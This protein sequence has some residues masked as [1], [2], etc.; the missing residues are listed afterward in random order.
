VS[1]N[2]T[3]YDT[4]AV[5]HDLLA[6]PA[7]FAAPARELAARMDFDG[8]R[9]ALDVGTGSGIVAMAAAPVCPVVVGS[10]PSIEMLRRA[11][12]NGI[13][14][15]VTAGVPGLPFANGAFDRV[16]AGFVLSHVAAREAALADMARV[17]RPGGRLGLTAWNNL[18]NPYRDFWDRLAERFVD[19]SRLVASEARMIPWE[20]WLG[21]SGNLAAAMDDAGLRKVVVEPIDC[22]VHVTIADFLTIREHSG[23]ARFLRTALDPNGW[24]KFCETAREEFYAR[25]KDPIDH[26]RTAWVGIGEK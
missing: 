19:A 14:R 21:R 18:S 1:N 4:A 3:S 25:F 7:W 9:A 10:D 2:W 20:E 5:T 6:V 8:A 11:R 24:R 16:T 26:V 12:A 23:K 17:L 13:A 22:P 15:V